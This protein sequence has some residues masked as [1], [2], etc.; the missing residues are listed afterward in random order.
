METMKTFLHEDLLRT[1]LF[2]EDGSKRFHARI[3]AESEAVETL[4]RMGLPTHK[5][6]MLIKKLRTDVVN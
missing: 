1:I 2:D 6:W 5:A 4:I 3:K